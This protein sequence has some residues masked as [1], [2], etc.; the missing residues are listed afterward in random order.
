MLNQFPKLVTRSILKKRRVKH[1]DMDDQRS[2]NSEST[3]D[4]THSVKDSVSEADEISCI[5]DR[6]HQ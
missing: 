2:A 6:L 1:I 5:S 4:A 3:N